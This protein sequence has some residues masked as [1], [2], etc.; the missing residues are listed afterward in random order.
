M[1]QT[2]LSCF[3]GIGGLEASQLRPELLCESDPDA[4]A[5]L[6]AEFPGVE[7]WHD[8][9]TL[10]PPRVDVVAGGWP[11]Q[12]L[13]IAGAKA[14]L[15]GLRSRLLLDMLRVARDAR[16]TTVVAE[17]VPNLLRLN[18]GEEFAA[19]LSAFHSF[20]FEFVSWRTVNARNFGLPQ[21]RTRLIL[22]AS[23]EEG[24]CHSLF[25][26]LPPLTD[27]ETDPAKRPLA[28]GFY[29][30]AG[31]HSI[32][33]SRGYV[34][35]IKVGSS[36]N[37][38]SPPAV[39]VGD[40]V[41]ALS[42][43]EALRLQGFQVHDGLFK[44]RSAMFRAA[45]NA[46]PKPIGSWILDEVLGARPTQVATPGHE[47]LFHL[48][49]GLFDQDVDEATQD[50]VGTNAQPRRHVAPQRFGPAGISAGGRTSAVELRQRPRSATNLID[51]IDVTD[52]SRLSARAARGLLDRLGRSGQ[53]C[54]PD[55]ADALAGLVHSIRVP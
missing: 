5:V 34:P 8:V 18:G 6:A 13:S 35:T 29:W 52:E 2:Y 15:S 37:I 12:D 21:N 19:S 41:R 33:Y 14:G 49:D 20:G 38:A 27:F 36:L 40:I 32:N 24:V 30:T 23:K 28:A 39:H 10:R 51:F 4:A 53:A 50:R 1:A 31:T 55:L 26:A 43:N 3:S 46:V 42:P 44:S 25:R 47:L 17:N 11:C 48:Q 22:V 45:G 7:I 54:P 16:A 9:R